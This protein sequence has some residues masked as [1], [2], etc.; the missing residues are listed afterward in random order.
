MRQFA[1]WSREK[2]W[3]V[4]EENDPEDE[5]YLEAGCPKFALMQLIDQ[6]HKVFTC[7][8]KLTNKL[9]KELGWKKTDENDAKLVQELFHRNPFMFEEFTKPDQLEMRMII[10]MAK[11]EQVNKDLVSLKNRRKAMLREYGDIPVYEKM[12][13]LFEEEKQSLLKEVRPYIREEL[14][15]VKHIK[16]VGSTLTARLLAVAHPNR[17]STKSKYLLYC[18][19]KAICWETNKYNRTAKSMLYL[20]AEQTLRKSDPFYRSLYDKIKADQLSKTCVDCWLTKK[21]L[22]CKNRKLMD[23]Q[24]CPSRAHNVALNRVATKIATEFW[25]TLHDVSTIHVGEYFA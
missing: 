7:D 3:V 12:I 11:Y 2:E 16:G 20:M 24:T 14:S 1:D 25:K 6:G 13:S 21:G 22:E 10:A 5:I 9:R 17:F 8:T 4:V 19:Y 15:R 18:G 23:Q